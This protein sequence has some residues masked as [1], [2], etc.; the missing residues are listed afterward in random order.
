MFLAMGVDC[1]MFTCCKF[2]I[3]A[4]IQANSLDSALYK[5]LGLL[6]L[7]NTSNFIQGQGELHA[8]YHRLDCE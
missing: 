6:C 2:K 4:A 7:E 8:N 1:S 5:T 3:K